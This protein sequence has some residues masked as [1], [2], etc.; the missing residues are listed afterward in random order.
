[1]KDTIQVEIISQT[2]AKE[3]NKIGYL[4]PV[5]YPSNGETW[6]TDEEA[7][8]HAEYEAWIEV[9]SNRRVFDIDFNDCKFPVGR[10]WIVQ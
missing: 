8:I 5:Y 3:C 1:M 9:E 4:P 2:Q 7:I 6:D 10:I